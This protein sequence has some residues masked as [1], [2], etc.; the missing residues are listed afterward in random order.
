MGVAVDSPGNAYVTGGTFGNFPTTPGAFQ[1]FGGA[2]D[3]FVSK[4][5]IQSPAQMI[6]N[7]ITTVTALGFQQGINLLQSALDQLNAGNLS[8]A[9]AEL[10]AF[11]KLVQASSGNQL[12]PTQA[13]ALIAPATT[14]RRAL[15]C[16]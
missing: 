16:P 9:C 11:I 1:T 5:A 12:T 14:I 13:N 7:L 15:G 6:S 4:I 3:A 10:N 2:F 8:A